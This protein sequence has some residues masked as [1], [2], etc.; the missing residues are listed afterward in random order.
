ME[1][2]NESNPALR[3]SVLSSGEKGPRVTSRACLMN[4]LVKWVPGL[5]RLGRLDVAARAADVR[6]GRVPARVVLR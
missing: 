5:A 6:I 3:V 4:I 2:K 1:R